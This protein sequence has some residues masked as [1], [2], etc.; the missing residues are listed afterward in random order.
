LNVCNNIGFIDNYVSRKLYEV[1][2]L[3]C[4][5]NEMGI[6]KSYV[7]FWEHD[8]DP[9]VKLGR[10]LGFQE[11][12]A[13]SIYKK[14]DSYLEMYTFGTM[15]ESC[16]FINNRPFLERFII[17]FQNVAGS[18][19]DTSNEARLLCRK[20][21]LIIPS[22]DEI[23]QREKNFIINTALNK[24]RIDT[25]LSVK[26]TRREIECLYLL[27]LGK[28]SKSIAISLGIAPRTVNHYIEQLKLKLNCYNREQLVNKFI[29][30][31]KRYYEADAKLL[32]KLKI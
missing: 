32:G 20:K 1:E 17:Y 18:L 6:K 16:D 13:F 4:C 21:K 30:Y 15:P 8:T 5:I 25:N 19:I 7:S 11:G 22:N 12:V 26:I 24:F 31:L 28:T 9:F 2:W 27:S 14:Y 10:S 3:Q 23:A 29:L